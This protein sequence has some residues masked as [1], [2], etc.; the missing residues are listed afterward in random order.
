M[1]RRLRTASYARRVYLDEFRAAVAK[2]TREL[3]LVSASGELDL[4]SAGCLRARIEEADTVGA[5]TVLVDLSEISFLDSAG[6]GV[7]VQETERLEGRGHSLVLV[8]NDPRTRRV[9]EVTGLNR[10]LRTYATL[11]DALADLVPQPLTAAVRRRSPE[12]A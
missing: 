9:V 4:Y 12:A 10:V 7:L 3:A 11:Q 2:L 8:T 5:D 1:I 6:L